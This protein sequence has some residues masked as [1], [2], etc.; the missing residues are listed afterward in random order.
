MHEPF[1]I[2]LIF[3]VLRFKVATLGLRCSSIKQKTTVFSS[4]KL[5]ANACIVPGVRE[6]NLPFF[7]YA[8]NLYSHNLP[9]PSTVKETTIRPFSE[10]AGVIFNPS[11]FVTTLF[12]P[13]PFKETN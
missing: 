1:V 5:G 11:K 10:N 9:L 12:L 4:A 2:V 8:S 6:I 3:L 13:S 7:L